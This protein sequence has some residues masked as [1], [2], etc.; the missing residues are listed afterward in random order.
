VAAGTLRREA[1]LTGLKLSCARAESRRLHS[2]KSVEK[3]QLGRR[4]GGRFYTGQGKRRKNIPSGGACRRVRG[5][6]G[7]WEKKKCRKK[8]RTNHPER[9]KRNLGGETSDAGKALTLAISW[10][11]GGEW[12]SEE[13]V[14]ETQG[15]K[16]LK[17]KKRSSGRGVRQE[18]RDRAKFV[19]EEPIK[20][21]APKKKLWA[22]S[23]GKRKTD[24]P[25][26][27]ARKEATT[28]Y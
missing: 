17:K 7:R 2:Q 13:K 26:F 28:R 5:A 1:R 10:G 4:E 6:S 16:R 12:Y 18:T 19:F 8:K 27:P 25:S 11:G 9:P 15:Q 22:G 3:N 24:S 23:K 14:Q 20:K 21:T